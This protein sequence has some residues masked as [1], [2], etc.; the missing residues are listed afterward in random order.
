[1]INNKNILLPED[2]AFLQWFNIEYSYP[3]I[4][5][6]E[7]IYRAVCYRI[8]ISNTCKERYDSFE[9]DGWYKVNE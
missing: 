7:L 2:E 8:Y 5:E 9:L 1:M 4:K 6:K 3:F